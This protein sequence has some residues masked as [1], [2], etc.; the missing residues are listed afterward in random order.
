MILV[1]LG[2]SL[3]E[4]ILASNSV[5]RATEEKI[6]KSEWDRIFNITSSFN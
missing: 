1:A 4:N 6:R 5:V 3:L 2:A